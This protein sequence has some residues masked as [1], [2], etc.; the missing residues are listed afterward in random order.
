ME[1]G[2]VSRDNPNVATRSSRI[3]HLYA[4]P[5]STVHRSTL[6]LKSKNKSS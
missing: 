3:S 2:G 5:R 1:L 6:G 4:L